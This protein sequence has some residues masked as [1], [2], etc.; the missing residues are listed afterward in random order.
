MKKTKWW[1]IAIIAALVIIP[2]GW[3]LVVQLEGEKPTVLENMPE[4][5]GKSQT[6]TFTLSDKRSGLR[7]VH[8]VLLKDGKQWD[9][10]EENFEKVGIVGGGKIRET[11]ID[12]PID[13]KKLGISDGDAV[14][15]LTVW[16]YSWRNWWHGNKTHMENKLLIDS[17]PPEIEILTKAHNV[18]QGG[19]GLIVYRL[20]EPCPKN[21]VV[22]GE[23]FFPGYSGYFKDDSIHLAFFALDYSQGPGTKITIE[24]SDQ[25]GNNTGSGFYHHIRKKNFVIDSI[26][27]SDQFLSWK[28]PEFNM[29]APENSLNPLLDN[30][31]MVNRNMRKENEQF[32]ATIGIMT[33]PKMYWE[34]TFLRLP[35]S[36]TRAGFADHR[37]YVYNGEVI[38]R[39]VHLG[40]DLAS[41]EKSTI[42]A[43]NTGKVL[44]TGDIGIYGKTVVIDHGFG[45]I[46]MYSHLSGIS[47]EVGQIVAKGETIGRTGITGLAG[48]DHLHFGMMI[49]NTM[50]NPIEWWDG[51]WIMHN[52]TDKLNDVKAFDLP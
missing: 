41:L 15:E 3:M 36:A 9:L 4:T 11:S 44:F 25:A 20:S 18:N 52:V 40:I 29:Q 10:L 33:E 16:D 21:G 47:V 27:L 49:H 48:G 7:K 22:V 14:F 8:A 38:D 5:I 50:I 51:N 26:K 6:F 42:P 46:S 23:N 12:V 17:K 24:A 43:S 30:F 31:L 19:S 32:L 37:E 35:N 2:A 34:G 39:Q 28:I 1:L 13:L 45:I